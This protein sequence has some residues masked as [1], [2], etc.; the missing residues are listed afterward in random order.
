MRKAALLG[1]TSAIA[2]L[3]SPAFAQDSNKPAADAEAI[4]PGDIVVVATR[5]NTLLSKTPLA[6]TAVTGAGLRDAGVTSASNLGELVP[7]MSIDRTNGLQITIRGVTSTDGT[8]KGDPS[9]AFLLDGIYLARPQQAD[10]GFFDVNHVEVLRG[11]QGTLYGRNTTAGVINVITNKPELGKFGAGINAGVGN[12]NA[13]NVDGYVNVAAGENAAFRLSAT[14]DQRDSFLHK[15]A[16]D[17]L[18]EGPFR[19]NLSVR[20]QA[21]FKINDNADILVRGT[22]AQLRGNRLTNSKA[23]NF[24]ST[25]NDALGNP[26]WIGDSTSTSAKMF[27]PGTLAKVDS[28]PF[29][30]GGDKSTTNP[31][32]NDTTWGIDGE[33]NWDFGPVKMTY[34]G[35]YRTYTAHENQNIFLP[36]FGIPFAFPAYFDGDYKQVSQ[37]LRFATTGDGPF[38]M[39][40]GAYYFREK[41]AIGFFLMNTPFAARPLYGF[42]QIP[43]ITRTAG[44]FA[45]GTYKPTES[46]RLTAG[47]RFTDDNK[48]R[49]GHTIVHNLATDPI[50]LQG[51]GTGATAGLDYVNDATIKGSKVTW[52]FGFDADVAGGLLYG[53]VASGYKQGGFGDGCST[54]TT[55]HIST[56]GE[57][58]DARAPFNDPQA[59]YYN[60]ETLTAYELGFRGKIA[61]GIRVDLTGFYYDYKDMQLSSTLNINGAPTLVTT[62]AGKAVVKGLE[63]ET[64]ITPAPNHRF[65]L[66]VDLLDGH[67]KEF[68]PGGYTASRACVAGTVNFAGRRLDRSPEETV[69]ANYVLTIP[70]GDGNF[71]ATAGT[72]YASKRFVT[73]F[74]AAP[75]QYVTPAHTDT[76]VSL[77]YNAAGGAWYISAYAKNLENFVTINNVDSFGNASVGDPRTF[78]VRAGY[79]F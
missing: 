65:T 68:C 13:W 10:V 24:Y 78:G 46:I 37:E 12:Y 27:F 50:A 42:P 38:K 69:Y 21:Y 62:N 59:I 31:S 1:L 34:L 8:E 79:K 48:Y 20:A 73:V 47:V 40:A 32:V 39:Q 53:S 55:T 76:S 7:N 2:L 4:Q 58:C 35:S 74:G 51:T 60:S 6:L 49:Y 23:G 67:Y 70:V 17:T 61:E 45:Q 28:T 22:Y 57:R 66:G 30:G 54:G 33:L 14:Y 75:I 56:Q 3:A 19:K 43:T 26:L 41:S 16:G 77:T 29:K 36:A 44:V 9:A 25:T 63:L 64:V 71:V 11:P 72:R 52:R 5:E 18:N 15:V